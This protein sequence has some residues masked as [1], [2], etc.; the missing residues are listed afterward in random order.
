VKSYAMAFW[1]HFME[2]PGT[3]TDAW[4]DEELLFDWAMGALVS[5]ERYVGGVINPDHRNAAFT[6][7][8]INKRRSSSAMLDENRQGPP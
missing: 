8:I 3:L 1:A 2:N 7:H 5:A 6:K 4:A